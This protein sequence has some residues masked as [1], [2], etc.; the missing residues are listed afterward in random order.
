MNCVKKTI[1]IKNPSPRIEA[2]IKELRRNKE[3][4]LLKLK[5]MKEEEF[6]YLVYL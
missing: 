5:N 6:D 3:E 1:V 2:W 4:Q